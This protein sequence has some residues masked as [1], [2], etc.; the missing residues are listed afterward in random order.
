MVTDTCKSETP[1]SKGRCSFTWYT[2]LA[3][4]VCSLLVG[5][6][7]FFR[8]VPVFTIFNESQQKNVF[9]RIVKE[10]FEFATL[11]HHSVQLTPVYEYYRVMENNSFK[12]IKTKVQDLGW[13]MPSTEQGHVVFKDGFMEFFQKDKTIQELRFRVSHLTDPMV[14]MG[15]DSIPLNPFVGDGELLIFWV[16]KKRWILALLEGEINVFQEKTES[17]TI[18]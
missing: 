12:V 6:S 1:P 8:S 10:G 2:V 14:Q 11:I 16:K 9:R 7:F 13:G 5:V 3:F 15:N 18:P 4:T 17:R